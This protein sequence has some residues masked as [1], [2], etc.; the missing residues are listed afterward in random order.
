MQKDY[1]TKTC[2]TNQ[3]N[4]NAKKKLSIEK[5]NY[6]LRTKHC[7]KVKVFPCTDEY[8]FHEIKFQ[9]LIDASLIFKQIEGGKLTVTFPHFPA[10]SV[11][12]DESIIVMSKWPLI[13]WKE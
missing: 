9:S 8:S 12:P 13:E 11:W 4:N 1:C 2:S 7:E 6:I 3:Y 5:A 10:S